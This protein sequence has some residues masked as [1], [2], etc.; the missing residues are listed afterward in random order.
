MTFFF[1]YCFTRVTKPVFNDGVLF[2]WYRPALVVV[3]D[4]NEELL[5]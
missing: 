2:D 5:A 1:S 4:K 3:R